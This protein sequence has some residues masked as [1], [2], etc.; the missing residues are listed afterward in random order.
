MLAAFQTDYWIFYRQLVAYRTAPT[1]A[2]RDRL[3]ARFDTLFTQCTGYL[4]L[5][6]RIAKTWANQELLLLVLEHPDLRFADAGTTEG[7]V[8]FCGIGGGKLRP[9]RKEI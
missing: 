3:R 8:D 6:E 5:D 7:L 2:E 1:A 4:A 9:D